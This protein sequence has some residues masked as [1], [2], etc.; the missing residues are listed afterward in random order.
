MLLGSLLSL[1]SATVV[2]EIPPFLRGDV[3][4]GYT[5]DQLSGTLVEDGAADF[6]GTRRL[7]AHMLQY[8]L[9]FGV[10]PG[11]AVF[12]E[13][14]HY[15]TT[16]VSYD[17]MGQMVFDPTTGGG[18]FDETEPGEAATWLTGTGLGGVWIGA[19]GTPFS[20]SFTRRRGRATWLL[21]GAVRTPDD[22]N[23]WTISDGTA[24]GA[25]PGGTALRLR[26]AF[27]TT[28]GSSRPY[29]SVAFV[30]EGKRTVDV[31][32]AAGTKVASDLGIDPAN[33]GTF[34]TGIEVLAAQNE[35]A[36]SQLTFD[37]HLG[38]AYASYA[39]LPSGIYLPRVL[40][41]SEGEAVQQAEQMEAGGGLG[42]TWRPMTYMQI[43][44]YGD[45]G[46][47]LRQRIEVPYPVYTDTDTLRIVAGSTLTV[48]IR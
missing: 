9:V 40:A 3:T 4:I 18:T 48:R 27:S 45:V 28:Y 26:S 16:S 15:V 46:Y 1:A 23:F 11:A 25:G 19:R 14:P 5:F 7:S 13:L 37:L 32:N 42:F 2:T 31:Y 39:L 36:G 38:I 17:A 35:A 44:V 6:A 20:E 29:M 22:S 34:R 41:A 8:G 12:V 33:T 10:A 21:E 43:G 30:S 24:R 47:H